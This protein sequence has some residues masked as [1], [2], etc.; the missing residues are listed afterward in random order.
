MNQKKVGKKTIAPKN[1]TKK[2]SQKKNNRQSVDRRKIV[3]GGAAVLILILV[4][5]GI[6][7]LNQ[8]QNTKEK[9][10]NSQNEIK[11]PIQKPDSYTMMNYVN[12]N[13]LPDE[14]FGYFYQKE[15]YVRANVENRVKIYMAISK[16]VSENSNK[17]G[18][19]SKKITIPQKEVIEALKEIFG[20]EVEYQHESLNGN[21]CSYSGFV[22]NE[23]KKEY[24]QEPEECETNRTMTILS[25]VL[26][27]T[28][29]EDTKE[30]KIAV[31]FVDF[32]YDLETDQVLY[33]YYKDI[34]KQELIGT[35]SKYDITEYRKQASQ[36]K[37][38]FQ[39]EDGNY[40]FEQV[41]KI[42]E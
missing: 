27:E 31:L 10:N 12:Q 17:Y 4:I 30:I 13:Q 15:N 38:T 19:P 3:I 25:E 11:N 41:E 16:V 40:I 36:Y 21:S 28:K 6:I 18:D 14:Y 24:V 34:D 26:E 22:Y 5:A 37:F 20:K 42:S 7:F 8:K 2:K 35:S 1:K 33:Q 39:E 23:D 9:E 29:S 32:T